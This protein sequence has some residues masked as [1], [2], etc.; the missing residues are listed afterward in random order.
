MSIRIL[1]DHD[2]LQSYLQ[3]VASVALGE[4]GNGPYLIL[5][6]SVS[7]WA[8]G[9]SMRHCGNGHNFVSPF[10]S[11]L[12]P[13]VDCPQKLLRAFSLAPNVLTSYS[14]NSGQ[15]L[16]DLRYCVCFAGVTHLQSNFQAKHVDNSN[17]I[18]RNY[19]FLRHPL[20]N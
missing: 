17:S 19:C 9:F 15:S 1:S 13:R 7:A 6:F 10:T 20:Q 12:I 8:R 2:F 11:T 16:H 4:V 5:V 18:D 3:S 14:W